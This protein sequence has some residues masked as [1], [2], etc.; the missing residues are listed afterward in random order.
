MVRGAWIGGN[1]I[2]LAQHM[3][4]SRLE[5]W[6]DMKRGDMIPIHLENVNN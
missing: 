2:S 4:V 5:I 3:P 6:G 1:E